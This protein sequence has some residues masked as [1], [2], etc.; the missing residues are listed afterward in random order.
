MNFSAEVGAEESV[1]KAFRKHFQLSPIV[2]DCVID[3]V[4]SIL[5]MLCFLKIL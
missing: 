1:E 4:H 3:V 2:Y 5:N